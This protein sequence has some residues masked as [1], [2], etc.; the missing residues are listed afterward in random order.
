MLAEYTIQ[1]RTILSSLNGNSNESGLNNANALI[2]NTWDKVFNAYPI[3]DESYRETLSCKILNHFFMREI[4][5]E[6]VGLWKFYLN[7]KMNEIMP[8]YNELYKTIWEDFTDL[9]NDTNLTR[10]NTSDM[11]S[12]TED[13]SSSTNKFNGTIAGETTEETSVISKN[14]SGSTSESENTGTSDSNNTTSSNGNDSNTTTSSKSVTSNNLTKHSD[15]PQGTISNVEEGSYLS[16]VTKDNNEN[17]ENGSSTSENNTQ[18]NATSTGYVS[19]TDKSNSETITNENSET[20]GNKQGNT[21]TKTD[22]TTTDET[23]KAVNYNDLKHFEE[24]VKGK[25]GGVSYV[26]LLEKI[27]DSIIN[28]DILIIGELEECFMQIY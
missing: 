16:D 20:I 18:M 26:E 4:C 5:C 9:Y 1:V 7:Q 13:T 19:S 27:R 12:N 2:H 22:N 23:N 17:N 24:I 3:W 6:T 11:E 25:S 8:Y 15:T 28:I 14:E 21:T 10:T